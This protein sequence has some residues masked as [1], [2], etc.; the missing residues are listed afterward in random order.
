M[1]YFAKTLLGKRVC[2]TGG[3]KGIGRSLIETLSKEGCNITAISRTEAD[4]D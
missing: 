1:S 4:L 2:V 3:G